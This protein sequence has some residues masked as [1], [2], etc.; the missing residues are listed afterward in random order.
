MGEFWQAASFA[1]PALR[2]LIRKRSTRC[3]ARSHSRRP[4]QTWPAKLSTSQCQSVSTFVKSKGGATWDALYWQLALRSSA[5]SLLVLRTPKLIVQCQNARRD[6]GNFTA[7]AIRTLCI[8][9]GHAITNV[10]KRPRTIVAMKNNVA[11]PRHQLWMSALVKSRHM[12]CKRP[13]PLYPRKRPRKR[14]SAQ[15]HVRFAPKS[16]HVQYN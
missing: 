1:H 16:G 12:Q 9:N 3:G 6:V 8:V 11:G 2:R 13:C 10:L 5:Q 7:R 4:R 14:I 15:G